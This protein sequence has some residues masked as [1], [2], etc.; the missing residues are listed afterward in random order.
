[1]KFIAVLAVLAFLM[2]LFSFIVIVMEYTGGGKFA[3][4]DAV[5]NTRS[6]AMSRVQKVSQR[7]NFSEATVGVLSARTLVAAGDR[8]AARLEL[9]AAKEKAFK[10]VG[11]NKRGEVLATFDEAIAGLDSRTSS[12][13]LS[14]VDRLLQYMVDMMNPQPKA[15]TE[16][17]MEAAEE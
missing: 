1:M 8:D 4:S 16:P 5:K 17:E 10:G 3:T 2:S 9:T 13:R 14:A 15:E 11:Q 6:A 7:A 12:A